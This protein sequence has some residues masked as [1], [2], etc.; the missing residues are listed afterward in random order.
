MQ[1]IYERVIA[2]SGEN[3][4]SDEELAAMAGESQ[5]AEST[6][7]SRYRKMVRYYADRFS[8]N[9]TDAEDLAQEGMIAL[10]H[11][12]P[13]F[14]VEKQVRFKAFAKACILNRMRSFMR[15]Q[16]RDVPLDMQETEMLNEE[17]TDP[18]TPETIFLEKEN[19]SSCCMRVMAILSKREWAILNSVMEGMSYQ[20]TAQILGISIKSVDNAMQRVR[21][22]MR[23]EESVGGFPQ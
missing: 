15:R 11:A 12:I 9:P 18:A 16:S 22:K 3:V 21:R 13:H 7:L 19:Y 5:G 1:E 8:E 17:L 10:L 4:P 6:L 20:Q 14:R 2:N 23:A